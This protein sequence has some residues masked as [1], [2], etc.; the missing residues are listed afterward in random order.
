MERS[1]VLSGLSGCMLVAASLTGC[2]LVDGDEL[3]PESG[4]LIIALRIDHND[5]PSQCVV[6]DVDALAVT[7]KGEAGFVTEAVADCHDLGMTFDG[8]LPG[9]YS[10]EVRLL[11]SAGDLKSEIVRLSGV[12]VESNS[13]R[14]LEV[15]FASDWI[16]A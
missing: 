10:V 2:I 5:D 7:I 14:V 4:S 11:D 3:E 12:A 6:Y 16:D 15:Y 8:L 9:R 1:K 13:D